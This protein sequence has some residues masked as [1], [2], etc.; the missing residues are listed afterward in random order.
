MGGRQAAE[1]IATY[2]S[3]NSSSERTPRWRGCRM[4]MAKSMSRAS[5]AA[6]T[7]AAATDTLDSRVCGAWVRNA[8]PAG[9]GTSSRPGP[10]ATGAS[11]CRCARGRSPRG[12]SPAPSP[13]PAARPCHFGRHPFAQAR[14]L[15]PGGGAHEQVVGEIVA[16]PRQRI[17]GG[18]LRQG[19]RPA[20][21][22]DRAA[23]GGWRPARAAGSGR[24]GGSSWREVHRRGMLGVRG[25]ALIIHYS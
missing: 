20:R 14:G 23:C 1:V 10:T 9:P 13:A 19:Q 15:Q 18:R 11:A 24:A 17:A 6:G 25:S 2:C 5:S 8:W 16:Q 12:P 7:S 22:R 3:R 4:P 21:G